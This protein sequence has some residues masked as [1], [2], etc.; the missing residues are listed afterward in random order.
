MNGSDAPVA[1]PSGALRADDLRDLRLYHTADHP[2]GYWPERQARDLV[3]DP[4]DPR[5]VGAYPL[6]LAMGF[7]RS[8]RLIYRPHCMACTDCTPVRVPVADFRPDRSQRRTLARNRDLHVRV[9]PAH[10]SDE[11]LEL[12]RRYLQARHPDGGMAAHDA[13]DFRQFLIGDWPHVRFMD[14]REGEGGPLL[15]VAVTD[16]TDDALSAVYTFYAPEAASRGLGTFAILQQLAWAAREGLDWL[17]LGFWI[18]GHPKMEYK[19]RF[20]PLEHYDGHAWRPIPPDRSA[21]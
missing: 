8:G 9:V 15:G 20:R 5:L 11:H 16:R 6:A 18:D 21:D 3:L 12:Y 17:Y 4:G 10:D 7:R 2:C 14:I 19:R 13:D 1:T